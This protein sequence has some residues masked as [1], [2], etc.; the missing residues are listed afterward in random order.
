MG[1]ARRAAGRDRAGLIGDFSD[2]RSGDRAAGANGLAAAGCVAPPRAR[3]RRHPAAL[4]PRAAPARASWCAWSALALAGFA[5]A[6]R[7]GDGGP[8]SVA[9]LVEAIA[10]VRR[11]GGAAGSDAAAVA[12][13]RRRGLPAVAIRSA[14]AT[15]TGGGAVGRRRR[16]LRRRSRWLRLRRPRPSA[17][18]LSRPE[19]GFRGSG[20]GDLRLRRGVLG[21]GRL[22]RGRG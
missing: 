1:P 10:S 19:L 20:A 13:G 5:A 16:G 18:R 12:A 15:A 3:A 22:Q 7:D 4:A 8:P 6:R 14:T 9:I 11:D 17:C 2:V 21:L